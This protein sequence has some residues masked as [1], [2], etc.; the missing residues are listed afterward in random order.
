[1]D[2]RGLQT[3]GLT[4]ADSTSG[5]SLEQLEQS[6]EDRR[7]DFFE[8]QNGLNYL[9]RQTGGFPIRGTNDLSGGI[10]RVL[11]D[12][13]GYY[14]IGYRP[15][16]STFDAATG[17]R[18]FH[19][20]TLKLKRPGLNHRTRTGF[21]GVTNEQAAP[22]GRTRAE[23]LISALTSP[24]GS[25]GVKLRLTSLYGNDPKAG[26]FVRSLIHIDTRDLTF[27]DEP[28]GWHKAVFDVMAVT[29][30]DN[31]VVLDQ[32]SR[33]HT[34]RARGDAYQKALN[35]GLVYVLTVPI[36][37]PGAYQLRTALRDTASE[38]V[39]SASQFIEVPNIG[40]NRLTLSGI[41]ISGT[42]PNAKAGAAIGKPAAGAAA[43]NAQAG[44][45]EE[46][47][48]DLDPQAGPAVRRFRRGMIL[49]YGYVIYNATTDKGSARP[50][51]QVQMRVFR[52]GREIFTGRVQ[53]L[54]PAGQQ[55]LKRL[56]TGGA[57]QLGTEMTPGEYILQ[58]IVTDPL[59][60]EKYRTATQWID[61]E[62]VK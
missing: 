12:Q 9:A 2:A 40:K 36:K 16:E 59:A 52:D 62:I 33:T 51:L 48:P 44:N 34:V 42:D 29:F 6:R 30:G 7:S 57:L 18:K 53:P 17:R 10:K 41:I 14:L 24:F 35:N 58:V 61:F 1:M 5:M 43:P 15:D 54:D 31:G 37:K 21:Y 50:Q 38:R 11:D 49:Q 26:G 47:I 60:K 22:Q 3:L 27:T 56:T 28:D 55:D 23:Q 20:I 13:K 25:G 39:G 19:K 45:S 8:S 4:A 32:M 46:V